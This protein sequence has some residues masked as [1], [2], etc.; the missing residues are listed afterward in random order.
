M[1]PGSYFPS[2]PEPRRRAERTRVVVVHEADVDGVS[3]RRV[4]R[5]V[6]QLTPA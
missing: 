4:D 6:V 3:T 1:L 2:F 5:L